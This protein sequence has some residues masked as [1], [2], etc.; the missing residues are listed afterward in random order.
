MEQI[1]SHL[2][3]FRATCQ[4]ISCT[5]RYQ[6]ECRLLKTLKNCV[7]SLY[8]S[9]EFAHSECSSARSEHVLRF[10]QNQVSL[11]NV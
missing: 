8:S 6:Q 11:T 10:V 3:A 9:H 2:E 4:N 7:F 1:L 5:I